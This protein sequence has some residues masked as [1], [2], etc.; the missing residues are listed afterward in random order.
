MTTFR[1]NQPT[2]IDKSSPFFPQESI[3]ND[4]IDSC[5]QNKD[6]WNEE[7][8]KYV[9]PEE[10]KFDKTCK[11]ITQIT[12]LIESSEEKLM[13]LSIKAEYKKQYD[14]QYRCLYP[15]DDYNYREGSWINFQDP[16]QPPCDV[17]PPV[18]ATKEAK[19][20]GVVIFVIDSTSHSNFLRG[21]QNF[22]HLLQEEYEAIPFPHLNK[23]GLN[24]LPN[25]FAF[26]MGKQ[27][28]DMPKSPINKKTI[29]ADKGYDFDSKCHKPLDNETSFILRQFRNLGYKTMWAEDWLVIFI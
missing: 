12:Q 6:P 10:S 27:A 15:K 24:S 17:R 28:E 26:L 7:I 29:K 13:R 16:T 5:L 25:G 3:E 23:V 20:F 4:V 14:C 19:G 8:L 2:G 11:P 1:Q 22:T 9:K 21:L 18:N